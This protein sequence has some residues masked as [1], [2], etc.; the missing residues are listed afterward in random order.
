MHE[1]NPCKIPLSIHHI[2]FRKLRKLVLCNP[3][4]RPNNLCNG[5]DHKFY[6]EIRSKGTLVDHVRDIRQYTRHTCLKY[7]LTQLSHKVLILQLSHVFKQAEHDLLF[8]FLQQTFMLHPN[9]FWSPWHSGQSQSGGAYSKT[10]SWMTF[11]KKFS[12]ANEGY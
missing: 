7:D 5:N 10:K 9:P 3:D 11:G 2:S 4:I 8:G 6:K 12:I 1:S